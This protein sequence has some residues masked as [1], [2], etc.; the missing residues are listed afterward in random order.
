MTETNRPLFRQG[1]RDGLPYIL[2]IFPFALLFGVVATEAGLDVLQTMGM[3]VLVIA[4]ASQFA[5][6][7]QMSDQ[8]PI[9]MVLATS[10]AVNLRMAMY[11]ASLAPHLGGEPLWRRALA[12]YMLVDQSAVMSIEKFE[13]EPEHSGLEKLKYILGVMTPV[14]PLWYG[15][16][17]LGALV[18]SSIPESFALDFAMPI[19]F[20]AMI[21]PM[22]K[23]LAHLAAAATSVVLALVLAGMPYGTGLLVAGVAAMITG[24]LVEAA[25]ERRMSKES[26]A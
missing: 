14:A 4:G 23:S 5:A 21:A 22:I 6:V 9:V 1:I 10:L 24:A 13:A 8:A 15:G 16:T 20:I 11:S 18:G 3:T 17:L 12:A 7:A 19:T 26:R 25:F 2:V